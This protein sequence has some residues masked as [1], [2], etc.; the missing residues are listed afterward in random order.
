M[1]LKVSHLCYLRILGRWRA[2]FISL[3]HCI[4]L[5]SLIPCICALFA[6]NS[7]CT[8]FLPPAYPF[9][10]VKKMV[11]HHFPDYRIYGSRLPFSLV[12]VIGDASGSLHPHLHS[13]FGTISFQQRAG[14]R[15]DLASLFAEKRL[16]HNTKWE[17]L[18]GST[19]FKDW[20][21][22]SGVAYDFIVIISTSHSPVR[23][24][25]Q[26]CS[27]SRDGK[28]ISWFNSDSTLELQTR[29]SLFLALQWACSCSSNNTSFPIV[30]LH[31]K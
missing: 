31:K 25:V 27:Y 20:L 6:Q 12:G 5:A 24:D 28:T 15:L 11:F 30:P 16:N 14:F 1:G 17:K 4:F 18:H 7:R 29:T 21:G 2:S 9:M 13:Y 26:Y 22:W 23:W 10:T 8:Y 3:W 19:F